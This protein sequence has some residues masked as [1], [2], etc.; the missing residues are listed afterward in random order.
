VYKEAL[1][2]C[3]PV[4]FGGSRTVEEAGGVELCGHHLPKV[5]LAAHCMH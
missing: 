2:L 4:P 1:R 3:T 5:R